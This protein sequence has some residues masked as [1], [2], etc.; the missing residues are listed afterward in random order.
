M[1]RTPVSK[2]KQGILK[3]PLVNSA[4]Y[5]LQGKY[6]L[7]S[8]KLKNVMFYVTNRCNS[9]CKHCLIWAKRPFEDLSVE[10]IKN[11]LNSKSVSK[12][13]TFG[14]EGGE[15]FEHPQWEEILKLFKGR[16]YTVLTN[17]INADQVIEAAK[18]YNIK[19]INMSLD[20][21]RDSYKFMRGVDNYDNVVRIMRE[22]KNV[23][24]IFLT[25][26]I[27]PWNTLSDFD[28]VKKICE[29][30]DFGFGYNIYQNMPFMDTTKKTET[31]QEQELPKTNSE[32]ISKYNDWMKGEVKLPCYSINF[33][34]V[35]HPNGNVPLCQSKDTMLGNIHK[36]SFDE[37]W[38]A[39]LTKELQ[40]KNKSCNGCWCSYHRLFDIKFVRSLEKVVPK[41]AVKKLIGSYSFD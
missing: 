13:T 34:V 32:Y 38:N 39:K 41:S 8:H 40:A 28:H 24:E 26:T 15:F 25:Y 27:S 33:N 9:R 17:G 7:K 37:I 31:V 23:S 35:I 20:G 30:N 3:V 22:L 2:I 29:D 11:V 10:A 6:W 4:A 36:Q 14:L 19:K 12:L 16:D 1:Y 18:K 5:S 21:N